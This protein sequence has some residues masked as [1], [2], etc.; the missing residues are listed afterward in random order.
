MNKK[1]E[2][3]CRRVRHY[4]VSINCCSSTTSHHH[5]SAPP[6]KTIFHNSN[7]TRS[8]II[9]RLLCWNAL[10]KIIGGGNSDSMASTPTLVSLLNRLIYQINCFML[11]SATSVIHQIIKFATLNIFFLYFFFWISLLY[12]WQVYLS[13]FDKVTLFKSII[14]TF[15]NIS[16]EVRAVAIPTKLHKKKASFLFQRSFLLLLLKIFTKSLWL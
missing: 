7:Y 12:S 6:Y 9:R 5:Y 11:L 16:Y 10:A 2:I 3:I 4:I 14:T 13:N 15:H 8:S 1:F